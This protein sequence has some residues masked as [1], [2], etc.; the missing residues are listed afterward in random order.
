MK[1]TIPLVLAAALAASSVA[2]PVDAYLSDDIFCDPHPCESKLPWNIVTN[3]Y[4]TGLF[5][6][7]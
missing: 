1:T 5:D 2:L 3:G 6:N 7:D 4:D